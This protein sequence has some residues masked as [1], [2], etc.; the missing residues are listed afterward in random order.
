VDEAV[1]GYYERSNEQGRLGDASV[2]LLRTRE[3]LAGWLPTAPA[4]VLDV[5][6]GAGVYALWL[7]AKGYVVDLIDPKE[8]HVDQARAASVQS[9]HPLRAVILGDARTLDRPDACVDA[10][11]L[12]GPHL[13]P[14]RGRRPRPGARR[15][16]P[17]APSL[18]GASPH[19]LVAGR[20]P[21]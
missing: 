1:S 16:L 20:R 9:A 17:G 11:L 8:K 15:G 14:W 21:I 13:P 10:V 5:G 4:E 3:L 6:G 12:L 2:A 7:A 19:V 18:L